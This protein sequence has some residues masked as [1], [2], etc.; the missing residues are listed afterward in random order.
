MEKNSIDPCW[1]TW[2]DGNTIVI[3]LLYVDDILIASNNQSKINQIKRKLME[4]FKMKDLG[5]P[6]ELLGIRIERDRK[7]MVLKLD[8]KKFIEKVIDK[9]IGENKHPQR[10]PM[11]SNQVRNRE[12]ILR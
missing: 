6:K 9:F 8:Q 7:R 10:S 1:F 11:V 12:R 4:E 2:K 3:L 5:E